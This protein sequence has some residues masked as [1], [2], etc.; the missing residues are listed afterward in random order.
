MLVLSGAATPNN[1]GYSLGSIIVV[2]PVVGE[3]IGIVYTLQPN[4]DLVGTIQKTGN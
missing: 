3:I 4:G 2:E 1:T